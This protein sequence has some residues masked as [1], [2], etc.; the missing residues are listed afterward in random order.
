MVP[1]GYVKTKALCAA[2]ELNIP[3]ILESGPKLLPDLAAACNARSDRLRQIMRTLHNNGIFTYDILEDSYQNNSTSTLLLQDHWTQWRNWVELYGNEFYD[4]ARGISESCTNPTRNAAQIN[5]DTDDSMFK[6]FNDQGWIP[7]FYKTL[8]GGATAQTPGI[9]EDYP[10]DEIAGGTVIDIG[11]GGGG[12][13]ALLRKFKSMQGAFFEAPHVVEQ[14]K[15]NFHGEKGEYA[16]V[17]DQIPVKN[18]VAG[19]FFKEV[20]ESEVYTMKW[21]LHDWNDENAIV[22]LKTIRR[23]IQKGAKNRLIVLESV[24]KDGHM[25]RVSRYADMNMMVAVGGMERDEAQWRKLAE[26]SGWK[27]RKIYPLRNAW[28]SAI[29]FIPVWTEKEQ[30]TNGHSAEASEQVTAQMRF[31]EPWD[32]S[33]GNPYV[34]MSPA[35]GYENIN[36]KWQDYTVTIQDARPHK[37]EFELDVHGFGYYDDAISQDTIDAL[38]G[39]DKDAVKKQY[40]PH[41]E[42]FVKKIIGAP[43]VIIFDHTMRKR[44]LELAKTANDEGKEQPATM[45]QQ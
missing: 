44:R 3:D 7:K 24:L 11:G 26:E 41:V 29:E 22:I 43:R 6:Y 42:A 39:N 5:Y 19:D 38:R 25:G 15:K 27:L 2:V 13:I 45:V 35:P 18:L 12:L 4:M 16:D 33:R 32:A 28:L 20:P 10:W 8:S 17:K 30:M 21:C 37:A 34:R 23:A 1:L 36:F 31:L 9:L 40:Y 14:V